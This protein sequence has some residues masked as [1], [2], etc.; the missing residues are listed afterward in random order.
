M[1][2]VSITTFLVSCLLMSGCSGQHLFTSS[3]ADNSLP[4]LQQYSSSRVIQVAANFDKTTQRDHPYFIVCE[5]DDCPV[6]TVKTLIDVSPIKTE[7]NIMGKGRTVAGVNTTYMQKKLTVLEQ[8]RVHF[9][10]ASAKL[11]K[12]YQSLLRSFVDDYPHQQ[13]SIRVTGYTDSG[14]K[15]DGIVGNEWLALERAISVKNELIDLGYPESQVLLEAKFLC[16]YID[17]NESEAGRRNN[18]RAE[19]TLIEHF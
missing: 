5:G 3:E 9:N 4:S 12:T 13:E 1:Q 11:S 19:I 17:S 15:P 16:C 2:H 8:F 7:P 18:R 14:T 10:Y 6:I